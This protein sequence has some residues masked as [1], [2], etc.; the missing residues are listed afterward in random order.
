VPAEERV[1]V[2][3]EFPR[4][5]P[6]GVQFFVTVGAVRLPADPEALAAAAPRLTV[7]RIDA[8]PIGNS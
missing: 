5:V 7:F 8:P 6:Y 2:L 4:Q 3:R 1:P